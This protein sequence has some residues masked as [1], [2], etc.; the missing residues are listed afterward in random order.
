MSNSS[1]IKTPHGL[2]QQSFLPAQRQLVM[3]PIAMRINNP[4][5][6]TGE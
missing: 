3:A 1:L 2:N 6:A 4:R 5:I